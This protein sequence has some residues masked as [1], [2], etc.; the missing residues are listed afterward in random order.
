MLGTKLP[1]SRIVEKILVTLP[2]KFEPTIASLENI[3]DLSNITLVELSNAFQA[4]EQRRLMRQE[5]SIEGALQAKL[6]N[7]AGSKYKKTEREKESF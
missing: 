2:E 6:Q 5:W 7:N 3:K 1:D 4:H